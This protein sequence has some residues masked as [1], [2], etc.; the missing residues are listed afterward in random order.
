MRKLWLPVYQNIP[1]YSRWAVPTLNLSNTG[2]VRV[3]PCRTGTNNALSPQKKPGRK[4]RPHDPLLDVIV[5]T[6]RKKRVSLKKRKKIME[7]NVS[8]W[9]WIAVE[10]LRREL[11]L[12]D[13]VSSRFYSFLLWEI[14]W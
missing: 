13:Q 7:T 8:P 2:T 3:R 10:E 5:R 12:H 14:K 6:D 9:W 11:P 1:L 4:G